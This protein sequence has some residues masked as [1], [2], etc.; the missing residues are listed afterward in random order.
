VS[1]VVT[2]DPQIFV[3]LNAYFTTAGGFTDSQ[4]SNGFR[5]RFILASKILCM[6]NCSNIFSRL[7][8]FNDGTAR[9]LGVLMTVCVSSEIGR[10]SLVSV[11]RS[12]EDGRVRERKLFHMV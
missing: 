2:G 8:F 5:I 9:V 7:C 11:P 6:E 4:L 10:W 1:V 12:L 3:N